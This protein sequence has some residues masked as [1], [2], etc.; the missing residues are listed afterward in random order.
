[1]RMAALKS[2]QET[3]MMFSTLTL[4]GDN[5]PEAITLSRADDF[6]SRQFDF[7]HGAY[8]SRPDWKPS[9]RPKDGHLSLRI[10]ERIAGGRSAVVYSADIV[11]TSEKGDSPSSKTLPHAQNLCV[12]I[13]RPNRC[14]TL[15]REAWISSPLTPTA[16]FIA[17]L[18][19]KQ[20]TFLP[21]DS[22]D[23]EL[24]LPPEDPQDDPTCDDPLL[25]DELPD[26]EDDDVRGARERRRGE[27]YTGKDDRDEDTQEDIRAM[28]DDL[29]DI[30]LMHCDI[31]PNNLVRAPTGA[32]LCPKH[33]CVHRSNLID[34]AWTLSDGH[35]G[36]EDAAYP[37]A[38][39]RSL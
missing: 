28:L 17:D 11:T 5:I 24:S 7:R 8:L 14:R 9:L 3:T 27:T 16:F 26:E 18:S 13:A 25:D 10:G 12:K 37:Q 15:A 20:I 6:T 29:S 36:D 35:N 2:V 38:A 31:R 23:F 22:K 30:F 39:A 1:M 21:W 34:F 19:P 33:N 32:K 4:M